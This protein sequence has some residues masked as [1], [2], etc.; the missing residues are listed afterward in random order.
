MPPHFGQPKIVPIASS[1]NTAIRAW[2][3]VQAVENNGFPTVQFP[4]AKG[5]PLPLGISLFN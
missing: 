1:R 3:V 4:T 5:F 2:Q